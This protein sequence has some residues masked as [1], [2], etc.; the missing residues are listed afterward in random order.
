[1][2]CVYKKTGFILY[3]LI[4]CL[5]VTMYAFMCLYGSSV[6]ASND[7]DFLTITT[8]GGQNIFLPN[9]Y[10][11]YEYFYLF[12]KDNYFYAI[13]SNSYLYQDQSFSVRSI[14]SSSI[15][16]SSIRSTSDSNADLDFRDTTPSIDTN[17]PAQLYGGSSTIYFVSSSAPLYD[18]D[19]TT[20]KREATLVFPAPTQEVGIIVGQVQGV[21]MN[22]TLQE[23]LGILPTVLVVIVGL[24]AI[25]K[26]IQFLMARMKKA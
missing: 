19:M 18:S 26:G 25:R 23:I 3:K 21:E 15:L 10:D 1:M 16:K 7:N 8:S 20:I 13:G 6:Y 17:R 22:K 11:N 2:E 9:E 5:L 12:S 24:L 4:P 14:D